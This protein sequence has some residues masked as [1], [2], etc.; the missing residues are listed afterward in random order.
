MGQNRSLTC[1]IPVVAE[2]SK[3]CQECKWAKMLKPTGETPGLGKVWCER[4]RFET[5]KLRTMEC[6]E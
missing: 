4:R 6:F 2:K 3:R 1:F 5:N